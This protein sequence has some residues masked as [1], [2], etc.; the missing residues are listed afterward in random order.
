MIYLQSL[1][2]GSI[3]IYEDNFNT[4]EKYL[5]VLCKEIDKVGFKGEW[6]GRGQAIMS[7]DSAK[8]LA[9]RGFKRIHVGIESLSDKTLKFFGK[10]LNYDKICR[11]CDTMNQVG[12]DM[13]SFFIIGV[14]TETEEDRRTMAQKIKNLGIKRPLF[15]IIQPLPNTRYYQDLLKDRTYSRD[16]WNDYVNNPTPDFMIPFPYG[17]EKWEEDA[18]F[19]EKLIEQFKDRE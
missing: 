13:I 4:D 15:S 2:A 18:D 8:M 11:F 1:G 9:D 10:P 12:I 5:E 17:K 6:S 14:P 16:Y 7:L 3:H 19:I